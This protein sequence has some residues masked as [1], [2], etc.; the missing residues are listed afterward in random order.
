[1]PTQK[2][3]TI[4]NRFRLSL[5]LIFIF[6]ILVSGC[7]QASKLPQT[8][9]L[10]IPANEFNSRV[11]LIAPYG[12]NNF[13]INDSVNLSVEVISNDQIMFRTDYGARIFEL[14]DHAW[15]E[16][17]N[18]TTYPEGYYLLFPSKGDPFKQGV[19]SVFPVLKDQNQP[20]R[21]RIVIIGNIYREG[22]MTDEQTAG[23]IDVVLK[24]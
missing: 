13:K 5:G 22:Q 12:L 2:L 6:M 19:A 4:I 21:L 3:K 7:N 17:P 24:P 14:Q 18:L 9:D 10:G 23:Y 15:V 16:V 1:M 20:V 8:P 11:R